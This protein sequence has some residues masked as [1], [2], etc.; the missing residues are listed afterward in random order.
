MEKEDPEHF[1]APQKLRFSGPSCSPKNQTGEMGIAARQSQGGLRQG[2]RHTGW[3][4]E[5]GEGTLV[6]GADT[7]WR[8]VLHQGARTLRYAGGSYQL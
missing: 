3:G 4:G 8:L 1:L 5:S 7:G 2:G 6:R